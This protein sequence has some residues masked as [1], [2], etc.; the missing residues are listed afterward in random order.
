M[1]TPRLPSVKS[2]SGRALTLLLQGEQLTHRDFQNHAATY[3]LSAVIHPL[4]KNGWPIVGQ[5]ERGKTVDKTGRYVKY[6]RYFIG[7]DLLS[8]LRLQMGERI[9]KFIDAVQRFEAGVEAT[10]PTQPICNSLKLPK[11]YNNSTKGIHDE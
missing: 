8:L 1:K 2:L 7:E 9:D 4:R 6:K 10:T 11:D 5:W 3:R